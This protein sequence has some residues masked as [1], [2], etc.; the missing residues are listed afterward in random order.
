MN[1]PVCIKSLTVTTRA[2]RVYFQIRIP[3]GSPRITGLNFTV[4]GWP[5]DWN[6][7]AVGYV[8]QQAGMIR[9]QWQQSGDV[10][11]AAPVDFDEA[12]IHDASTVSALPLPVD[13]NNGLWDFGWQKQPYRVS[14]HPRNTVLSGMYRDYLIDRSGL[15]QTYEVRVYLYFDPSPEGGPS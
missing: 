4:L 12:V 7:K 11:F 15:V 1:G 14:I 13:F 6:L 5:A 8:P 9:L 3:Q 2:E 10:F